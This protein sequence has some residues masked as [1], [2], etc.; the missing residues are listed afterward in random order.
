MEQIEPSKVPHFPNKASNSD[1][2]RKKRSRISSSSVHQNNLSRSQNSKHFKTKLRSYR[3]IASDGTDSAAPSLSPT[4]A[5]AA[6]SP[7]WRKHNCEKCQEPVTKRSRFSD[8]R[9]SEIKTDFSPSPLVSPKDTKMYDFA[10][11]PNPDCRQ[12]P[13]YSNDDRKIKLSSHERHLPDP[14]NFPSYHHHVLYHYHHHH[15]HGITAEH[16]HHVAGMHHNVLYD[17]MAHPY[18]GFLPS[19]NSASEYCCQA[20]IEC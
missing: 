2:G 19:Q 7:S 1:R 17:P 16:H 6:K 9:G 4:G 8:E 13:W 15:H 18:C 5:V 11:P 14:G 3:A 10:K 20:W 12:T